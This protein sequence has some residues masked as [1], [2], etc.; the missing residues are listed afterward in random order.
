MRKTFII[1]RFVE[2]AQQYRTGC[3]VVAVDVIWA[4]TMAITAVAE[5]RRC[6]QVDVLDS[7]WE[8][9]RQ[10]PGAILAGE[11]KGAMPP[12]IETINSPA[13]LEKRTDVHRPL[14]VVSSSGTWLNAPAQG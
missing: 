1:D 9:A 6:Y 13:E 8:L 10:C 2:C 7:A 4:T 12:D 3:A 11:V 5:G 14:I